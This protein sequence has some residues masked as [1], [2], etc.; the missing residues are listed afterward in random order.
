[1]SLRTSWD[2]EQDLVSKSMIPSSDLA[3]S[4]G[5]VEPSQGRERFT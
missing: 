4:S 5:W 3:P 2:I 1:M